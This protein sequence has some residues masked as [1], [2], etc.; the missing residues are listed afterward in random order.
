M[1]ATGA[2]L[3]GTGFIG[4]VHVEALRRLG[5]HV[6]GV[7]GSTPEK[8]RAAADRLQIPRAFAGFA[9]LLSDPEVGVVHSAWPKR[10]H[11]DQGRQALAAGKHVICEKPLAMTV[12]ETAELVALAERT[13]A[14][15]AVCYNI[16]F[17]PLCLEAR[18]RVAAGDLGDLFHVTGS[19]VQD[20]LLHDTDFN[21]RVLAE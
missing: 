14:V 3:V 11:F 16:R 17:Y 10:D 7:L 9:D 13:P 4:P 12:A 20:W 5:R 2:A 15:A 19:Y 8:G 6:V 21:W 1:T 18:Q